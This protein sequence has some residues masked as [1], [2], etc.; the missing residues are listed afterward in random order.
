MTLRHRLTPGSR[1][2]PAETDRALR[3]YADAPDQYPWPLP[4]TPTGRPDGELPR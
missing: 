3:R 1:P 4:R 2:L